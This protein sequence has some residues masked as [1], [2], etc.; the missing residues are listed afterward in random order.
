MIE[1]DYD[2]L[3]AVVDPEEA[4]QDRVVL[5]DAAGTNRT[6]H[7]VWNCGDV[8]QA[9]ADAAH[10]VKIDRLHF[11]RFSST[12][13]EANACVAEWNRRNELD[14]LCNNSSSASPC[15]RWRPLRLPTENPHAHGRRGRQLRHQDRQ[16]PLF[17]AGRAGSQAGAARQV[18]GDPFGTTSQ[19]GT[20]TIAPSAT[21][22]SL[23]ANGVSPASSRH[24]DDC[25]AFRAE[26][27]AA[28][29]GRS[30][31]CDLGVRNLRIDFTQTV[32]NKCPVIPTGYSRMQHLWFMER[33][34]DICGLN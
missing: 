33:V 22:R 27:W 23:D 19:R 15:S 29:S 10:V 31:A 26:P 13:L 11:H 3:D 17:R 21:P 8:D 28:S 24:I 9:F 34:V 16:L 25:G 7:G 14:I 12:P 2:M 18:S 32:T 5:H 30:A 1:V 6:W 4:L 20:A